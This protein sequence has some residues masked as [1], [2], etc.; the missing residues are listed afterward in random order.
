MLADDQYVDVDR[1]RLRYRD[2]GHGEA[3]VFVHGWTL[4]LDIWEP[5]ATELRRIFR[6]IRFDRRG[7]GRSS[8]CP[9]LIDD[10]DDLLTLLDRLEL[11]QVAVV[12]MSQGARVALHAALVSPHRISGLV[13]DGSPHL[14]AEPETGADEDLPLDHY[15]ELVRT[16]GIDAFRREWQDHSFLKL[17]TDDLRAHQLLARVIARYPGR[18]LAESQPPLVRIP[19]AR[20]VAR[21]QKPTLILNGEFDTDSRKRAGDALHAALPFAE[22]ALV[23]KAGHLANLDNPPAYNGLVREFLQRQFRA[24]A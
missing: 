19:D 6:V 7:F 18:D 5:Q 20:S 1:G 22:R 23:P 2:E 13:L 3:V 11:S 15:R 17:V 8:G 12:G 4:D 21:V 16:A 10:A 14:G 9:S 24:A